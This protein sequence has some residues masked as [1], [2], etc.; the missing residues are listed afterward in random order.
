[1]KRSYKYKNIRNL[2]KKCHQNKTSLAFLL[3]GLRYQFVVS[4]AG[5]TVFSKILK[6]CLLSS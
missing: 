5:D 2:K 3:N 4:S 6:F 1:M